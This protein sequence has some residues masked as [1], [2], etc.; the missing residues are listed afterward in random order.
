MKYKLIINTPNRMFVINGNQA[1]TPLT[2]IIDEKDLLSIKTK[3]TSEGI[4]NF[5]ISP[6]TPELKKKEVI[7]EKPI[8]ED[9]KEK[10]RKKENEK[11]I[12]EEPKENQTTLEKLLSDIE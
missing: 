1:R 4:S 5:S 2:S 3:I 12:L 11:L 6:Y 8:L 9:K 7:V 10:N